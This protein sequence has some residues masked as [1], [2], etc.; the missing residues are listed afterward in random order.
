MRVEALRAELTW[1]G[2]DERSWRAL[3]LLP[4]VDVAWADGAIQPEERALIKGLAADRY[5]LEPEGRA[6]LGGWLAH[7][8]T[9]DYLRRGRRALL[10]LAHGPAPL[11]VATPEDVLALCAQV[12]DA[13]GGVFGYWRTAGAERAALETIAESL[14]IQNPTAWDAVFTDDDEVT[15]VVDRAEVLGVTRTLLPRPPRAGSAHIRWICLDVETRVEIGESLVVGRQRG[16]GLQIVHDA[17]V[18]RRHCVFRREPIGWAVEDL[19]SQN[20]TFVNGE[21]VQR[22]PLLGGERIGVGQ[23]ELHFRVEEAG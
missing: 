13:A 2:F 14:R 4:L 22:R 7:R 8:P 19:Q 16:A 3:A 17:G 9:D 6:L 12:A 15:A 20:G 5:R 18:S 10:A 23:E 11:A 21:R 1:L